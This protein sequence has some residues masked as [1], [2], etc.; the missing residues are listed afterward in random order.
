MLVLLSVLNLI[1]L[2]LNQNNLKNLFTILLI[3]LG[4]LKTYSQANYYKFGIGVNAGLTTAYTGFSYDGAENAPAKDTKNSLDLSKSKGYGG[5]LDFYITPFTSAG[6]EYNIVQLR[7]GPDQHKRE[8]IS[9]FSSIEI[10][11][12]VAAG[13]FFDF[14][15]S[16]ILHTLRTINVSLGVGIISGKNNVLPYNS[17][18]DGRLLYPKHGI[19]NQFPSSRQHIKDIG[20]SKFENV[21]AIPATIGY[22]FNIYNGY[23]EVFLQFGVNYK[24]VYTFSDDIDGYNDN[25]GSKKLNKVNDF[26]TTLGVSLKCMFG[27]RR[28][29]Y[30]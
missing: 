30:R 15:Y 1:N 8:F 19:N 11:G 3:L 17:L 22:N 6:V 26:Y 21:F 23:D 5:S 9:D 13:Q 7:G 20:K 10:R 25:F 4:T 16:P 29:F 27:P 12:N 28:M 2:S 14:S 18:L 24:L